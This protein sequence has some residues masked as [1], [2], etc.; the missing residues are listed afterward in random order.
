MSPIAGEYL[1]RLRK[2]ANT[3]SCTLRQLQ[4][5]QHPDVLAVS[6]PV[7]HGT[8]ATAPAAM[9][10]AIAAAHIETAPVGSRT[11]YVS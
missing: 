9:V 3:Y 10:A 6:G 2:D 1:L 11:A 7:H 4:P 8:A 5:C